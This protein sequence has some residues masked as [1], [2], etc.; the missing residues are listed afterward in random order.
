MLLLKLA[1]CTLVIAWFC[2][3]GYRSIFS[4]VSMMQW[5][6][7]HGEIICCGIKTSYPLIY[8]SFQNRIAGL[9]IFRGK[10]ATFRGIFRGK[11][12]EKSADFA[13]TKS[14]FAGTSADFAGTFGGKLR[15]ETIS[16]KQPISLDLFGK[17]NRDNHLLFQ[18]Q[19]AREMSEC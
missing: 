9:L 8:S 15:Q 19:F 1:Y 7:F 3:N 2:G 12:A 16:E 4:F 13:G 11:F 5:V 10:K 18:Q 6:S 17:F 14:N